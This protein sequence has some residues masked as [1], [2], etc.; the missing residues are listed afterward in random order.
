LSDDKFIVGDGRV[1]LKNRLM[2]ASLIESELVKTTDTDV[3]VA[4]MPHAKLV[5]LGGQSILDRGAEAV[6]PLIDEIVE[7][8][9]RHDLMI[10]VSGGARLRHVYQ[11]GLDLGIPTGGLAQLGGACEEQYAAIVQ[12][13]LAKHGGVFLQ[14][15]H[16]AD[17]PM[18]FA[19]GL[20]PICITMPPYHYWEPPTAGGRLPT[21]GSDLGLFMTAEGMGAQTCI[22]VKDRDGLYDKDPAHH[23]D[24]KLIERIGARELMARNLDSLIVDRTVIETLQNARFV[25][26]I[27]IINGL[28][29]GR[30]T[31]ALDGEHVGTIVFQES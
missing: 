23:L 12:Q 19:S 21:N 29:K 30:L 17:L 2:G 8:K 5:G 26:Q 7:A 25:K 3:E 31:R 15:D 28:E 6:F 22:F 4:M 16:F 11:I 27:Q 18:Y 14:R 9:G 1:H 10:G 20:I 13:L 24:A